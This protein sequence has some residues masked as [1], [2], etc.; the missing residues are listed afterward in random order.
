M[1]QELATLLGQLADSSQPIAHASLKLLSALEGAAA[2]LFAAGWASIAVER[3]RA[4]M[5]ALDDLAEESVDFDFQA[6]FQFCLTDSDAEIRVAALD[7]LWEDER[8]ALLRRMLELMTDPSGEV[9]AAVALGLGRFSYRAALGELREEQSTLLYQ[10]LLAHA[11]DPEEPIE[12]RR[13]AIEALGY[14][15]D[16]P[17]GQA[18]IGRAYAHSEPLMRESAVTAMGRSMRP[19]WYPYIKRELQSPSPALRYEAA[20]AVGELGEDGQQMVSALLPLVDDDDIEISEAAIW[21]LG[22]V[23]G[24]GARRVLQRLVRSN[25][26]ERRQAAEEAISELELDGL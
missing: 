8:P 24:A 3:R 2:Q 7:G 12:V 10:V 14:F 23:G 18:E 13:R 20:R 11:T 4:V 19:V 17:E 26:A 25:D 9:R 15:A 6:V 22:Q 21:A 16:H 5:K 1:S